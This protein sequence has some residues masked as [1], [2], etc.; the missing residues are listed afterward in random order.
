MFDT[1]EAH[2]EV[3]KNYKLEVYDRACKFIHHFVPPTPRSYP[4]DDL[5]V[6]FVKRR[7]F[8][9]TDHLI[10]HLT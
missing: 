3:S 4:N 1:L 8:V 6:C 10:L 9:K 7:L 5:Y 2:Q